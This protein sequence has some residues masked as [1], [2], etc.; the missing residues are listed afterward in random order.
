MRGRLPLACLAVA[1]TLAGAASTRAP[2]QTY[3]AQTYDAQTYDA[4]TYDVSFA[5]VGD[6]KRALAYS[7]AAIGRTVSDHQLTDSRGRPYELLSEAAGRPLVVSMVFTACDSSCPVIIETLGD[8]VREAR[9]VLGTNKF[10]VVTIGFDTAHDTPERMRLFAHSLGVA[11]PD[12]TFLSGD[13]MTVAAIMQEVGFIATGSPRGYDHISQVSVIDG[14]GV[15]RQHVY[16]ATFDTPALVEPLKNLALFGSM[17]DLTGLAAAVERVR[18]FCTFY[19]P[20][21]GRYEL[22]YSILIMIVVGGSVLGGIGFTIAR[23]AFRVWREG[24]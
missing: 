2:A 7:G 17:A 12:C 20:A 9:A 4:Q 10:S 13:A 23:A 14:E 11:D 22:D 5:L 15:I 18:L 1:L 8:A 6:P 24:A 21:L 19:D 16:G 3:D